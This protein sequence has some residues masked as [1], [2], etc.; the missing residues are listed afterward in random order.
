M[1]AVV[2]EL[3]MAQRAMG[4]GA[5]FVYGRGWNGGLV[6]AGKR[7]LDSTPNPEGHGCWNERPRLGIATGEVG[8]LRTAIP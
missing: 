6:V 1:K 4:K 5:G 2:T 8:F 3:R 7:V